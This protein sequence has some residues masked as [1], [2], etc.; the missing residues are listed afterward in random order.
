MHSR[1][2]LFVFYFE[3]IEEFALKSSGMFPQ[4]KA[5]LA[6]DRES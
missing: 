5:W 4:E 1:F 3:F 2:P 6:V